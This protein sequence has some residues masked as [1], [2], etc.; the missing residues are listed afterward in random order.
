MSKIIVLCLF[1]AFSVHSMYAQNIH[2]VIAGGDYTFSGVIATSDGGFA[3]AANK[4]ASP[5]LIKFDSA[6]SIMWSRIIT[7]ERIGITHGVLQTRHNGYLLFGEKQ[8][9]YDGGALIKLDSSGKVQWCRFEDQA[10]YEKAIV[11]RDGGYAVVGSHFTHPDF[12]GARLLKLDSA[13][14]FQWQLLIYDT[15]FLTDR[16]ST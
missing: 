1:M 6:G 5:S 16:K 11:T 9:I 12:D 14:H 15:A 13:C 10:Y 2:T 4:G 3:I 7:N 8:Y